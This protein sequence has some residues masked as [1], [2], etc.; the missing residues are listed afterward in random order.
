MKILVTLSLVILVILSVLI[1]LSRKNTTP[2]G[3]HPAVEN[4]RITDGRQVI[5]IAA[6]GG[7]SP[8]RT[9]AKA[10][11]PTTVRFQTKG[12]FDCSSF[13]IVPSLNISKNLQATGDTDI[14]FG[15]PSVGTI[16]GSCAMG[17]YPFEIQFEN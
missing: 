15:T 3:E 12:T 2:D 11:I 13:V 6:K 14:D 8:E 10:G 9:S 5:E 4:V 17:M 7:Y 1:L 16:K